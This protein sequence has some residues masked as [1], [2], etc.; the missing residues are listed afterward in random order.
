LFL[1]SQ[2]CHRAATTQKAPAFVQIWHFQKLL[3]KARSNGHY[4]LEVNWAG[5]GSRLQENQLKYAVHYLVLE[6]F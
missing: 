5:S 4:D 1:A 3:T 6:K 2:T